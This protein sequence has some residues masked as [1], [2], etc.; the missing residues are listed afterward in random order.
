MAIVADGAAPP[1]R[2]PKSRLAQPA[3]LGQ[4]QAADGGLEA[5]APFA[6]AFRFH[7]WMR[8]VEYSIPPEIARN[9]RPS[10]SSTPPYLNQAC[11]RNGW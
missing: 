1:L 8:M 2:L 5:A 9:T 10:A 3:A 7:C 6:L 4:T 11:Q